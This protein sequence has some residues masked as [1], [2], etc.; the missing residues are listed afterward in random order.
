[1]RIMHR[2]LHLFP[3][4]IQ[5]SQLQTDANKIERCAFGQT[6]SQRIEDHPDFLDFIF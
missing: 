5:I 6:V 3:Y 4:E 1:M 2:D